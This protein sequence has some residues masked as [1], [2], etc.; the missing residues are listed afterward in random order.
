MSAR[1]N[2]AV[3]KE[4]KGYWQINVQKNGTR[5]SF[6][7]ST[8]GAKGRRE[9]NKKADKWLDSGII[10]TS[11]VKKASESFL[12][13]LELVAKKT[14]KKGH[15]DNNK[16]I[17][18]KWILPPLEKRKIETLTQQDFQDIINT[19]YIDKKARKTLKNI[20]SVANAFL[21]YCRKSNATDLRLEDVKIYDD[22]PKSEKKSLQPNDLEIL[23]GKHDN[24]VFYL[25]AFR[26]L[27]VTGLRRG[28][29]AALQK[30]R[31]MRKDSK[32]IMITTRESINKYLEVT[33]CKTEKSRRP[34]YL[35]DLAAKILK[36]Q[37]NMLEQLNI[38]SKYIF[39][40]VYGERMNPNTFYERWTYYRDRKG[41][42]TKASLHE[43]RHTFI[44]MCKKVPTEYLKPYVG[45][46][47]NM[48]TFGVY[49][50]E[51]D[52]EHLEAVKLINESL[53]QYIKL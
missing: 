14:N 27:V 19:A 11:T 22:A 13:E 38:E 48:D 36:E 47:E 50:H 2:N 3:W 37:E 10:G 51:I 17:M 41:F 40:N 49:G 53:A 18:N 29:L 6:Y 5:R 20:L 28:E 16:S 26:F 21:K 52:G 4:N 42:K 34:F 35:T 33:Q 30:E 23:F 7:S 46:T 31:D 44:S 1:T 43:L 8:P 24:F 9:C 32:G 45:H 15:Y 25:H 12:G 39:P